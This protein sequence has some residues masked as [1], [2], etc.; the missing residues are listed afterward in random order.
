MGAVMEKLSGEAQLSSSP[1]ELKVQLLFGR[2]IGGVL[3][4]LPQF[5]WGMRDGGVQV[6]GEN[7]R[8]KLIRGNRK[9]KMG[10]LPPGA[11][12]AFQT[13]LS[14]HWSHIRGASERLAKE[15][16]VDEIRI[17]WLLGDPYW[18]PR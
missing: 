11:L 14:A 7:A 5:L 4:G 9:D 12:E 13:S 6:W 17:D 15:I 2:V 10:S 18:G 3:N 16:G 1:L 8:T